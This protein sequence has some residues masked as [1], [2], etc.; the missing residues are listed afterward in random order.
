MLVQGAKESDVL[1]AAEGSN[2]NVNRFTLPKDPRELIIAVILAA[3]ILVNIVMYVSY[4]HLEQTVDLDRYDDN[5]FIN[6]RFADLAAQ[7]RSDHELITA[8]GLQKAV[9]EK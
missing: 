7:V 4:R 9:K 3:S 8:Y 2:V 1:H 6:G 5:T